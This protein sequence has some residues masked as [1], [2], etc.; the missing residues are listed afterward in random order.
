MAARHDQ[1]TDPETQRTLLLA[2]RGQAYFSRKLAELTDAEL[3]GPSLLPGWSRAHVVAHVGYNARALTRL[4]EWANTGVETPMYPTTSQRNH[5]IDFGATLPAAALRNLSA[6]AAVHLTVEWRD[7]PADKWTVPVRTAQGRTVPV[8]ETAWMRAREVWLHAIDLDNGGR[9][10]HLPDEFVRRL[11][12]EIAATWSTRAQ[13][14]IDE[15]PA[16]VLHPGDDDVIVVTGTGQAADAPAADAQA[17]DAPA[18]DVY[19]SWTDLLAW[20]TGRKDSGVVDSVGE[21]AAHAPRWL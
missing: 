7:L 11:L 4:I 6:H 16:L 13:N 18:L 20:A 17:A 8:S 3:Y 10:S 12:P 19:G 15:I 1:V 2:R 5:E 21:P 9:F 14:G